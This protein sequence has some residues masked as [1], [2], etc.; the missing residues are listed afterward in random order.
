VLAV[1]IDGRMLRRES[2]LVRSSKAL[3]AWKV[4][5]EVSG[6]SV[7]SVRVLFGI[8]VSREGRDQVTYPSEPPARAKPDS[9]GYDQPEYA[10]EQFHVVYL[11]HARYEE[12]Q[13]GCYARISRATVLIVVIHIVIHVVSYHYHAP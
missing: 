3:Y 12:A 4:A 8:A 13:D 10:S 7:L 6:L 11:A 1:N 5:V 9:W 2:G